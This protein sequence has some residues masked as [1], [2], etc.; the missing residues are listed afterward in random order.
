MKCLVVIYNSLYQKELTKSQRRQN[1]SS[2]SPP[3]PLNNLVQYLVLLC[4]S[5]NM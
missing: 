2:S 5:M 3:P 4:V 1:P